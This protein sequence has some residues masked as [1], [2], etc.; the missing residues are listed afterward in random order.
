MV[1]NRPLVSGILPLFR[2]LLILDINALSMITVFSV[3]KMALLLLFL[4]TTFSCLVPTLQ[5]SVI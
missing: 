3:T 1:L 2:T 5:K 4:W